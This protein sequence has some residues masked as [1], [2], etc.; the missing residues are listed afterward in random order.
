[1]AIIE[2]GGARVD[3]AQAG[4]GRNLVLLHSL[5]TDRSVFDRVAP[6][7]SRKRRLTLVNLPGYG[8]SSP[9]GADIESYAD[10]VA[11]TL[12]ALR[13]PRDTDILGN[14]FGGF[15]A[16]MLAVRHGKRFDRL[17]AAPALAGFPEAAKA[18]F[19]RMAGLVSSQGMGAVLD[20]A[21]QRMLPAA[22]IEKHPEIAA[23]RRQSLAKADAACFATACRALARLDL[24][25]VLKEIKNPTLVMAGSEDATTP[26]GLARELA[27]GIPG[28]K[29]LELKGCG[30]C[31][32]VENPGAFVAALEDFLG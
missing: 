8:G 22:F 17:I 32:Q 10:R 13:L 5:L 28:A 3:V 12:E 9:A 31:P 26:P 14:G 19:H 25:G 2:A 11:A 23:Q 7:L 16:V 21:I 20:A 24:S 4:E 18:P 27:A 15:I 6:T 30:H 1:M 29:F